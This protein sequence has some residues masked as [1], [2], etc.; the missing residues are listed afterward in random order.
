MSWSCGCR[1]TNLVD[2]KGADQWRSAGTAEIDNARV[3]AEQA[4]PGC[5][6]H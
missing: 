3:I 6:F 2:P 4:A 5:S 1:V